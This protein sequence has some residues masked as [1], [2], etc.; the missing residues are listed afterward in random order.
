V[1]TEDLET[2]ERICFQIEEAQWFYEDFVRPLDPTLPQMSLRNFALRIFQHC[3]LFASFPVESHIAAFEEFMQYKTRIPV[4]GAIMLN[5]AM[6]SAVL[7]KGWKKGAAW[8]FP[9]GKINMDEDDLDCAVREVYE[10]TGFDIAAAGLVPSPEEVKYIELLLKGQQVRLYVFRNVP[11]DTHFEPKTRK[12]ISGIQWY[13]LSALPAFKGKSYQG[14]TEGEGDKTKFY[15]VAPFLHKLKRWVGEQRKKDAAHEAV[16]TNTV[17]PYIQEEALTEDDAAAR[18]PTYADAS[19]AVNSISGG[20][21]Q[22]QQHF[23]GIHGTQTLPMQTEA[24]QRKAGA[25]ELMA[26]LQVPSQRHQAPVQNM[27]QPHTP[28][29]HI[30][31]EPSLPQSP[32]H[33]QTGHRLS[34]TTYIQPPPHYGGPTHPN[35]NLA[36][37]HFSQQQLPHMPQPVSS[38]QYAAPALQH[39]YAG[40][41]AIP[42][43]HPQPLPPQVQQHVF[44]RSTPGLLDV[45]GQGA[46][47]TRRQG[48]MRQPSLQDV[49]QQVHQERTAHPQGNGQQMALLNAF[50]TDSGRQAGAPAPAATGPNALLQLFRDKAS[51]ATTAAAAPA[52]P[53]ANPP[54]VESSGPS[55]GLLSLLKTASQRNSQPIQ[56]QNTRNA[57]PQIA[58]TSDHGAKHRSDLLKMFKEQHPNP[59]RKGE[60]QPETPAK[61]TSTTMVA[62]LSSHSA[63]HRSTATAQAV[64]MAA[65]ANGGPVQMNPELH[66][67]FG[68]LSILSRPKGQQVSP[69]SGP[70]IAQDLSVMAT[71][72]AFSPGTDSMATAKPAKTSAGAPPQGPPADQLRKP[73]SGGMPS[74][75]TTQ[76]SAN[77]QATYAQPPLSAPQQRGPASQP[78]L[79]QQPPTSNVFASPH[80]Q[81]ARINNGFPAPQAPPASSGLV[82]HLPQIPQDSNPERKK[83]LLALFSQAQPPQQTRTESDKGKGKELP[84]LINPGPPVAASGGGSRSR[85]GS[86]ASTSEGAQGNTPISPADRTFLLDLLKTATSNGF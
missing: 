51:A 66:L 19:W 56:Q 60:E 22:L 67:P 38:M 33:H 74:Q 52:P 72:S 70:S 25:E 34:N 9:R 30:H 50:R 85:I 83:Q 77:K 44:N 42:L 86:L 27:H 76:L 12:E 71:S 2:V 32:H 36:A 65:Q 24:P 16:Y 53:I 73:S 58:A 84:G 57:A 29:E 5:D 54:Q 62:Q 14:G 13:K 18:G 23:E 28:L 21:G 64:E 7:V 43:V 80:S 68:A 31:A 59:E 81:H 69:R 79:P 55:V 26:V 49:V 78:H 8:S 45:T 46:P 20:N 61:V 10:E 82:A 40:H 47:G 41:G 48:H 63:T 75:L 11:M 6:D 37:A 35:Y 15:M 39:H 3:P 4:R 17:S 1:P